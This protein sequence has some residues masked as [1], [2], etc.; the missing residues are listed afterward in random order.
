M[1]DQADPYNI[2]L[3]VVLRSLHTDSTSLPK[4]S[5]AASTSWVGDPSGRS[6]GYGQQG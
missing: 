5:W 1:R 3:A 4:E 6:L 2:W